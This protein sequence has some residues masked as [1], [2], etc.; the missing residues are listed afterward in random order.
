MTQIF[1]TYNKECAFQGM[2]P[3]ESFFAQVQAFRLI[4]NAVIGTDF[5]DVVQNS[6]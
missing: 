2:L 5:A 1:D 6:A 3:Y 4:Q